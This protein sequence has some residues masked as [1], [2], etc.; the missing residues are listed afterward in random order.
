[1]QGRKRPKDQAADGSYGPLGL[2]PTSIRLF[3]VDGPAFTR[4]NV[5]AGLKISE[6]ANAVGNTYILAC[7]W[8]QLVV[9]SNLPSQL[10][11]WPDVKIRLSATKPSINPR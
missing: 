11:P 4:R 2:I 3:E 7:T 5:P 8:Q 9:G 1:M 10:I 6:N